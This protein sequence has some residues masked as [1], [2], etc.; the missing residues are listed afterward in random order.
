MVDH[1]IKEQLKYHLE[2]DAIMQEFDIALKLVR[3]YARMWSYMEPDGNNDDNEKPD[4]VLFK[5][6]PLYCG[7]WVSEL[8]SQF[9][10]FSIAEVSVFDGV[11]HTGHLYNALESEGVIPENIK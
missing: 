8:R 11:L 1:T 9:D 2:W 10:H 7:L 5:R 4:A 3:K 6:H